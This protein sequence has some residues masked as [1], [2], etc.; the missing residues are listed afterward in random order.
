MEKMIK[1]IAKRSIEELGHMSHLAKEIMMAKKL[2]DKMEKKNTFAEATVV[3]G[4]W[5]W[6][7]NQKL[8][9][10]HD[11]SDFTGKPSVKFVK[12]KEGWKTFI[13]FNPQR[14]Y[15]FDEDNWTEI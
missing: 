15:S 2:K 1:E 7:G 3:Y 13:R 4:Q 11:S 5:D 10:Q 6:W 8:S 12:D 14:P 9:E